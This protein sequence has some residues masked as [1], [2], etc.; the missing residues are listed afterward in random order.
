MASTSA[1]RQLSRHSW[2]RQLSRPGVGLRPDFF[3]AARAE[4]RALLLAVGRLR[5][6]PLALGIM[7]LGM[8][9]EYFRTILPAVYP[10]ACADASAGRRK[11]SGNS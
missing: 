6:R 11:G 5:G 4:V 9:V 2:T 7:G 1:S 8:G 3:D 10:D